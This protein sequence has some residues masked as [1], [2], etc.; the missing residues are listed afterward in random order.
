MRCDTNKLTESVFAVV[1]F[2]TVGAVACWR[3]AT[4]LRRP[5]Q[6]SAIS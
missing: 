3:W 1:L 6:V 4:S 5:S 2:A